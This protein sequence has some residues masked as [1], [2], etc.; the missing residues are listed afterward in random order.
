MQKVEKHFMIHHSFW[1]KN[2]KMQ[3]QQNKNNNIKYFPDV[4]IEPG[5]S[6]PES[7]ALLLG[8]RLKKQSRFTAWLRFKSKSQLIMIA[9]YCH[10]ILSIVTSSGIQRKTSRRNITS[11]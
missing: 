1:N 11:L 3:K 2:V 5:T 8:H 7:D 6:G 10:S 9:W 4:E